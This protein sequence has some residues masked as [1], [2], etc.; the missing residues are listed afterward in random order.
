MRPLARRREAA[1]DDG[2]VEAG[3]RRA[4]TSNNHSSTGTVNKADYSRQ[5]A[6]VRDGTQRATVSSHS[7]MVVRRPMQVDPPSCAKHLGPTIVMPKIAVRKHPEPANG[8]CGD[9]RCGTA[10]FRLPVRSSAKS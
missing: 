3:A 9:Y 8:S 5:K 10:T 1:G 2:D 6:A 4:E 7:P